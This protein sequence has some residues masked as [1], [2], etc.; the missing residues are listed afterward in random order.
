M[1][2]R[3]SVDLMFTVSSGNKPIALIKKI[4]ASQRM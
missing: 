1:F 4:N 2:S 3:V